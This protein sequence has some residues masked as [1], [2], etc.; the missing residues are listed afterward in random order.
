MALNAYSRTWFELFLETQTHTYVETAF[1]TR[2]LA[3]GLFAALTPSLL[4]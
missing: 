4:N 2:S 1:L 3:L